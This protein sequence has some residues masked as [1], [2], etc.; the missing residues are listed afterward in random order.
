MKN[1]WERL[2]DSYPA[3]EN[4]FDK[5]ERTAFDRW[6]EAMEF[7]GIIQITGEQNDKDKE[8]NKRGK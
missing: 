8:S 1:D 4:E 6:V 5:E 3:L 7:D 2:R